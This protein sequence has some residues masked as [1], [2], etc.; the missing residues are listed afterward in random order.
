MVCTL[1][2]R[3]PASFDLPQRETK[4]QSVIQTTEPEKER[5][6]TQEPVV[7]VLDAVEAA[8]PVEE[9]TLHKKETSVTKIVQLGFMQPEKLKKVVREVK[10]KQAVGEAIKRK[11][12]RSP[13]KR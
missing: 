5:Q 3:K 6:T 13:V 11:A 8:K 9:K 7:E 1:G 4:P 10:A 2:D 12:T